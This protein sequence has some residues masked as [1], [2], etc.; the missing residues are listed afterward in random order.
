MTRFI[1]SFATQQLLPPWEA[2]GARTWGFVIRMKRERIQAYLDEY[3]N[4][5][6]P[7]RAPFHYTPVPGPQ[8]G[9]LGTAYFPN[10]ASRNP[11][12]AGRLDPNPGGSPQA[13]D[14]LKHTEV[15]LAF[16]ALRHDLTQDN[17]IRPDPTLVWVEPFIFSDNDS[18]VF[19][20][21]EIWGSDMYL[22]SIARATGG[23]PH[24]LHIDVGMAGV[25]T[26]NPRSMTE[27]IAVLHLR[28]GGESTAAIPDLLAADPDLKGFLEILVG[29]GAFAAGLPFGI[30]PSPFKGGREL[31][32]LKQFRD[33]FNMAA[34]I[35]RGIVASE[36]VH[37]DIDDIVLFDPAQIE[38]DFMWSDS[39]GD[40]LTT[41]LDAETWS[42]SGPPAA[43]AANAAAG[44]LAGPKPTSVGPPPDQFPPPLGAIPGAM[45][46]DM[47]RVSVKAEF[48]FSF[49]SNV[50]FEVT[51]TIH[52]YGLVTP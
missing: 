27:L 25:K 26:F 42:E 21:R 41:L 23:A 32:N 14:H 8:F 34:A 51:G 11:Q 5:A 38:I 52:T 18:V 2:Q 45:D 30:S 13:W 48:G 22:A 3:F 10:V 43:H 12:T 4:G 50:R 37:T 17:L 33:C 28:T 35:Y 36:T 24:E 44:P 20:S 15:Y 1:E 39:I 49:S 19:S 46:W 31:N 29:S 6:Y 47:N 9:L 40:L 16:P 7:D